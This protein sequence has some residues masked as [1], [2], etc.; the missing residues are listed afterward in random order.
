MKV[1]L[2]LV[3]LVVRPVG[4][5]IVTAALSIVNP[6]LRVISKQTSALVGDSRATKRVCVVFT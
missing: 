2:L 1:A 3:L 6:L 5:G 4:G